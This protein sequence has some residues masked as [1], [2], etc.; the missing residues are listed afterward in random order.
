MSV[1]GKL[2]HWVDM[3]EWRNDNGT[4]IKALVHPLEAFKLAL[5]PAILK[6]LLTP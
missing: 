1:E 6:V 3:R 2:C 4:G 5:K